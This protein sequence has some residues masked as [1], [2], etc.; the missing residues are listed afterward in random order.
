[1]HVDSREESDE[2][3]ELTQDLKHFSVT[4]MSINQRRGTQ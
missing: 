4:C 2:E 3:G 1:M